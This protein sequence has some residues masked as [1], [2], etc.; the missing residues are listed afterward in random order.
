MNLPTESTL[1]GCL[2]CFILGIGGSVLF[3]L[4]SL[5]LLV[6]ALAVKAIILLFS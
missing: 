1:D 6:G 5:L 3:A 4:V 2:G